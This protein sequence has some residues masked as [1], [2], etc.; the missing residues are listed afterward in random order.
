[1]KMARQA[2]QREQG[3]ITQSEQL[4]EGGDLSSAIHRLVQGL[5]ESPDSR[6]LES[7]LLTLLDQ[8]R[9]VEDAHWNGLSPWLR[10]C[11]LN[12]ELNEVM[13]QAFEQRLPD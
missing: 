5:V 7:S 2:K 10:R 4:A 8:R 13:L 1:M 11:E 3:W 12:L 6:T 9:T